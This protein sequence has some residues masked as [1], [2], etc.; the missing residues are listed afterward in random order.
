[1]VHCIL[2][3]AIHP[4]A[5]FIFKYL[6]ILH[7][8][9]AKY[10]KGLFENRYGSNNDADYCADDGQFCHLSKPGNSNVTTDE[11]RV[12]SGNGETLSSLIIPQ[13]CISFFVLPYN[14]TWHHR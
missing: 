4:L 9:A 6:S 3:T 13:K 7:F 14:L 11:T 10:A 2:K 8:L 5:E 1:M 12:P